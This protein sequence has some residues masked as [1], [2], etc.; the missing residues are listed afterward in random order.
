MLSIESV[1]YA[2]LFLIGA[3]LIFGLLDYM[4]PQLAANDVVDRGNAHREFIRK[5]L[6]GY[7]PGSVAFADAANLFFGSLGVRLILPAGHLPFVP[8]VFHVD[9]VRPKKQVSR[10]Y[11][12]GIVAAWAVVADFNVIGNGAVVDFPREPMN[13][14]RL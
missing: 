14:D 10:V 6:L 3:A 5:L 4:R 8:G 2:V 1:V 13:Q 7:S 11:A 12:P 9:G